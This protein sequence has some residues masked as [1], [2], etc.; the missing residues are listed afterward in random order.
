MLEHMDGRSMKTF[1]TVMEE[2]SFSKAA[3]KLGYVQSTVTM[4]IHQLEQ[5]LGSSS[6]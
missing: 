3:L 2:K 1:I 4:H 6:I 5:T